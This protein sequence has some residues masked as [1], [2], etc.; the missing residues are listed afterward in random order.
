MLMAL[1]CVMVR[2]LF[3]GYDGFRSVELNRVQSS[4][5]KQRLNEKDDWLF[6]CAL[7]ALPQGHGGLVQAEAFGQLLLRQAKRGP[8]VFDIHHHAQ[9]M[10]YSYAGVNDYLVGFFGSVPP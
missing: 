5:A 6:W 8:G 1:A 3:R 9:P 2:R 7:P 10:T 4:F